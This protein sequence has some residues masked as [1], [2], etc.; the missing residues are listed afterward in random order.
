L[1]SFVDDGEVKFFV[2]H[3]HQAI[4]LWEAIDRFINNSSTGVATNELFLLALYGLQVA[5]LLVCI[6]TG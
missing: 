6:S 3:Q 4:E 5:H 1:Q 2:N